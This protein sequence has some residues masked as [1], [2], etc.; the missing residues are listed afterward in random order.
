MSASA[1]RFRGGRDPSH[2]TGALPAGEGLKALSRSLTPA[3]AGL[4]TVI[5][6]DLGAFALA[7]ACP[8]CFIPIPR[9]AAEREKPEPLGR[10]YS[11]RNTLQFFTIPVG[12]LLGG[13]LVDQVFVPF[14][15]AQAPRSLWARLFGTGKG[16]GILLTD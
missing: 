5:F 3:L 10:V 15:S 11:A 6:F 2:P 9:Q 12:Y 14:M 1:A 13:W 8:L 16:G 7:A 4:E